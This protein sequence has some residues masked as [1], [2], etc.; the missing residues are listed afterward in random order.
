MENNFQSELWLQK[1]KELYNI[2]QQRKLIEKTEKE[3]S[4]Q[5][6]ALQYNEPMVYGGIR[7][8]YEE[9]LGNINYEKISALKTIDFEQYRNPSVRV[10][11]LNIESI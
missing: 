3:L 8:F 4:E 1:A 5:L 6:K 10:W 11:K 2:Q 7:Y 9:R